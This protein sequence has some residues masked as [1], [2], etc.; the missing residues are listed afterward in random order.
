L[1]YG[2]KHLH[3]NIFMK[4][5]QLGR[6]PPSAQK[7]FCQHANFLE[8]ANMPTFGKSRQPAKET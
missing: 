3:K 6:R 4:S 8:N 5:W 7:Y 1:A 2:A